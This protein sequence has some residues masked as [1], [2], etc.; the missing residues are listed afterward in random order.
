MRLQAPFSK[1]RKFTQKSAEVAKA[2]ETSESAK[3]AKAAK[4]CRPIP[5]FRDARADTLML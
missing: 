3:V 5:N 4:K 1:S 2:A